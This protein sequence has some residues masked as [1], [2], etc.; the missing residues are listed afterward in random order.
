MS[1]KAHKIYMKVSKEFD[2]VLF[3]H[4]SKEDEE[5]RDYVEQRIL[6]EYRPWNYM[7]RNNKE[8]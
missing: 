3:K 4:L 2:R 7:F 8:D 6:D 1:D 5:T